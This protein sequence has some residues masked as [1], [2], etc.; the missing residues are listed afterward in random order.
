MVLTSRYLRVISLWPLWLA[1]LML[2]GTFCPAAS[3]ADKKDN[4]KNE[5]V[6]IWVE[7]RTPHFDVVSD[8]GEKTARRV[9]DQFEQVRG[10]FQATMP[11]AHF[12]TGV[13][14]QILAA[15]DGKS[16][17]TLFPE[18]PYDKRHE[19]P[20]GVFFSGAEKNYIALRTN[21]S[22]PVPF[23]DIYHDYA[24]L[25]LKLSYNSLPPWLEAGYA[26]VYG[27]MALTA[28]GARNGRPD[29]ETV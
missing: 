29:P 7:V 28:K 27:S 15:R 6:E 14:I 20:T 3:A 19:Q 1:V 9:A 12:D 5:K 4:K 8:G 16:F 18:Y 21:V 13:P 2:A 24:R 25:V 17:A 10:I 11:N 26:N 23:E 22:G